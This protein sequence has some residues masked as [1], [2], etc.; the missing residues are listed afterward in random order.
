M[1]NIINYDIDFW[2]IPTEIKK[3]LYIHNDIYRNMPIHPISQKETIVEIFP[4][5][6]A[7]SPFWEDDFSPTGNQEIDFLLQLEGKILQEYSKENTLKIEVRQSVKEKLILIHKEL[8]SLG[9]RLVIKIWLRPIE[10]Q[11]RLFEEIF[12]YFQKSFPKKTQEYLYE[13]VTQFVSDPS[14]N[15][16]PHTT[17]G[18]VD[19]FLLNHDGTQ[20]DM[21]CPVNHIWEEANLTTEKISKKQRQNRNILINT[22]LKHWFSSLASEWWHFSYGDPYWAKFYGKSEALYWIYK[23]M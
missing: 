3:Y 8:S 13:E 9:F 20:V 5:E 21:W 17:G 7:L 10:V 22:F 23:K 4:S 6:I 14:K 15:I 12:Q 18:A 1:K 19:V 16:S 11:K 2:K